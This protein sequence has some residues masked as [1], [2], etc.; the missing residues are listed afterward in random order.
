MNYGY[1][2]LT[3]C[4]FLLVVTKI[5]QCY[6]FFIIINN[7]RRRDL[8]QLSTPQSATMASTM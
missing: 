7:S 3:V 4:S 2:N 8:W 1:E 5:L 6:N